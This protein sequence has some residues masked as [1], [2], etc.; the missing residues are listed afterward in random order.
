MVQQSVAF[1]IDQ[2]QEQYQSYGNL[3]NTIQ[4]RQMLSGLAVNDIEMI[5]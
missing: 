3:D 2:T 5:K 4:D 1:V